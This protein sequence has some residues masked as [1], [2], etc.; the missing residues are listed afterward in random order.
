MGFAS[1]MTGMHNTAIIIRMVCNV[2]LIKNRLIT[3]FI[4][5]IQIIER[6]KFLLVLS[7]ELCIH[8]RDQ[9]NLTLGKTY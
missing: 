8:F 1:N 5:L 7:I 3:F 2:S 9:P 4:F 6:C